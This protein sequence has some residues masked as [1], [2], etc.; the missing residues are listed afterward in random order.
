[1][2]RLPGHDRVRDRD[3]NQPSTTT[4]CPCFYAVAQAR[5][6]GESL[7]VCQPDEIVGRFAGFFLNVVE[8]GL[9][10][11]DDGSFC[12]LKVDSFFSQVL[13]G[14]RQQ[15]SAQPRAAQQRP[16]PHEQANVDTK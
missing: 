1:M 13:G 3:R 16:G 7:L 4:R 6:V 9:E 15:R 12:E 11:H 5:A 10:G 2:Q 14:T 8:V